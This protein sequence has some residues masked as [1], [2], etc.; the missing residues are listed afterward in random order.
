MIIVYHAKNL[1][2][3]QRST[4][5]FVWFSSE[6]LHN[7]NLYMHAYGWIDGV[8]PAFILGDQIRVLMPWIIGR[9]L[10]VKL[11]AHNFI[12]IGIINLTDDSR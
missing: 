7:R 1:H 10:H 2:A 6:Q 8:K 4:I 12:H 3:V 5:I 9:L 11:H